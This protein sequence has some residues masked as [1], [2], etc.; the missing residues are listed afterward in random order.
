[1]NRTAPWPHRR[2]DHRRDATDVDF[3][4]DIAANTDTVYSLPQRAD[5]PPLA[6]RVPRSRPPCSAPPGSRCQARRPRDLYLSGPSTGPTERQPG[7]PNPRQEPDPRRQS[8]ELVAAHRRGKVRVV[9]VGPRT[10]SA[11]A[12]ATPPSAS[13]CS[14]PPW[15]ASGPRRWDDPTP[16]TLTARSPTSAATSSSAAARRRLRPGV[17]PADPETHTTR[18][19]IIDVYATAG[20]AA[21]RHRPQT[22]M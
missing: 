21:Q 17:A 15:P 3:A 20:S 19:V 4:R 1:M 9:I 8:A 6:R 18:H 5:L 11:P 2:G 13:T 7:Q 10:S 12:C 16:S 14:N 22:A